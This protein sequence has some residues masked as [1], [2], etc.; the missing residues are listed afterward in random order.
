[1]VTISKKARLSL[2][3]LIFGAT[4][5]NGLTTKA[6]KVGLVSTVKA[7]G[8]IS[9][10]LENLAHY[11]RNPQYYDHAIKYQ[12]LLPKVAENFVITGSN[13]YTQEVMQQ[14]ESI[15]GAEELMDLEHSVNVSK[16]FRRGW[17]EL[18]ARTKLHELEQQMLS[19]PALRSLVKEQTPE[20]AK[21]LAYLLNLKVEAE[22][23]KKTRDLEQLLRK[24]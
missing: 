2:Q 24:K 19:N 21:R 8:I 22:Q 3:A 14:A 18:E 5:L 20:E 17:Y 11:N 16:G 1:M 12:G 23:A 6:N 10:A 4:L 13:F 7:A 9:K 15:N